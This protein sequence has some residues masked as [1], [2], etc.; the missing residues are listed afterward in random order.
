M[1][2]DLDGRRAIVTGGSSGIGLCIV[3]HLLGEGVAVCILD[4]QEP[5]SDTAGGRFGSTSPMFFRTNVAD[6]DAVARAVNDAAESMGGLD[7]VV[8][9]AGITR[10]GRVE[11]IS[12]ADWR[13]TFSVNV[14]GVMNVCQAAI[15]HLK[16]SESGRIINAA[17]FAAIVPSV[18]G[19]AYAASKN[20]VITLSRVLASELA[21]WAI[22]VNSYAP[23][24][25]PTAMNGF[26]QLD[27]EAASRKLAQVSLNRWGSAQDIASLISYLSSDFAR[28]ITGSLIDISGGKIA[29]QDPSVA[30]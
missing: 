28:Y 7:I 23:G 22:T 17:S 26:A 24:M 4:M 29:T 15:P 1:K 3:E 16:K 27:A 30:W 10:K 18:G 6:T 20:A 2:I 14:E 12:S 9:N 19:A 11:D 21:P 8:N 25:I 13:N 5:A